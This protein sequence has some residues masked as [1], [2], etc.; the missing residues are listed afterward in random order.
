LD[1]TEGNIKPEL[2]GLMKIGNRK[3]KTSETNPYEQQINSRINA[4]NRDP[5]QLT[6]KSAEDSLMGGAAAPAKVS[7][8]AKEMFEQAN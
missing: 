7:F 1:K 4:T 2:G 3:Q 5:L 8:V 6:A